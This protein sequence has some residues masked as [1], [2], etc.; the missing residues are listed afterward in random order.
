MTILEEAQQSILRNP[1]LRLGQEVF[2]IATE[3]HPCV[4]QLT[5]TDIDPFYDDS[6]IEA[7]LTKLE[8]ILS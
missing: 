3:R 6:R 1:C 4:R 7:F 8:E 2:N 5:G